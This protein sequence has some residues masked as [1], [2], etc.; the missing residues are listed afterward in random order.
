MP[1]STLAKSPIAPACRRSARAYVVSFSVPVESAILHCN[2]GMMNLQRGFRTA[3]KLHI[4][5]QYPRIFEIDIRAIQ[6]V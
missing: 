4:L 1:P 6:T 3:S 5:S 2:N